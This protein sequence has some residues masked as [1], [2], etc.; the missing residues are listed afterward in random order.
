MHAVAVRKALLEK[1]PEILRA[2]FEA[3]S[4]AKSQ[5]YRY[6]TKMGWAA[7]MLPWYG[8]EME[9]TVAAMGPNWYSYGIKS[10]RNTLETLFRYS[11][12]QGLAKKHLTIDEL[13]HPDSL[14]FEE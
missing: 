1:H 4:M 5:A 12:E 8:Q 10:N 6:M 7:D 14:N 2:I 13:F 11:Y 3:Y 9:H